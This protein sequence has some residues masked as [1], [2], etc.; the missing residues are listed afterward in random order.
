VSVV[1]TK[2]ELR[3]I[4]LAESMTTEC[5]VAHACTAGS[6]NSPRSRS[7]AITCRAFSNA[8]PAR[9]STRPRAR[10]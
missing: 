10:R 5:V 1:I 8:S 6:T 3:Y 2:C 7:T 4:Q 9:V